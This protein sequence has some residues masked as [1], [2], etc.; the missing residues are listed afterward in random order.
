VICFL[1]TSH[2]PTTL[3]AAARANGIP[4]T[5]DMA[6]AD[7]VFVSEDTPTDSTG[8]RDVTQIRNLVLATA[9]ATKAPIVLSSQVPPGFT[10]N[11]GVPS[12]IHM[13]ETLRI[14]DAEHR[15][16]FPE[17]FILGVPDPTSLHLPRVLLD[18][19][20][21][22][23]EARVLVMSY[24]EAEFAKIAI[25]MMLAA[26]VDA[27]NRLAKAA[28]KVGARWKPIADVLK[29]DKRIGPHAYLEPGRW[30][31]SRHLL[32]DSVTLEEIL[33]R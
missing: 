28:R 21:A 17:Q 24:E 23:G 22:H 16:R 19:V 31:D 5:D 1:G 12:V 13:A 6:E 8:K 33:A 4:V 20:Y 26:Q 14:K 9:D 7:L 11:L 27:T 15:A 29:C 18:Y 32:R 25:N 2:A 10:R 30:E 3:A